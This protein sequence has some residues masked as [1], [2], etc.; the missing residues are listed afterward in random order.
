MIEIDGTPILLNGSIPREADVLEALEIYRPG[1]LELQNKI[2]GSTRVHLEGFCR[3]EECNLG[4]FIADSMVDWNTL[5]YSGTD[6]WTDAAIGIIQGGGVRASIEKNA[7]GNITME[8]VATVMPFE[9][10]V[11]VIE[12]TGKTLLDAFEHSVH[13]Y[14]DGEP[15]GEFLQFSGVQI[16]YDMN[17]SPGKRVVD[18]KVLCAYCQVPQLENVD[19][20]KK[21]RAVVQDFMANGGDGYEM[22][23]NS[24]IKESETLDVEILNEFITKKSPIYPAVEWRITIKPFIDPS[25]EIVGSSRVYLDGN[26][27]RSECNL[28]NFITDSFVDWYAFKYEAIG[29][30]TDASIAL[31]QASNIRNSFD[32]NT[33]NGKI[34]R[35]DAMNIL[36]MNQKIAVVEISGE[37]L[38]QALEHSVKRYS[39]G[40]QPPEFLQMSG[41]HVEFDMNKPIGSRV[42]A[43]KALC[44]KC[45]IPELEEIK[46]EQN[47]KILMPENLANGA[48]GFSMFAGRTLEVLNESELDAFLNYLQKKSPVYQAVEW[49]ITIKDLLEPSEDIVGSTRVFLNA[50]CSLGECNL[51]NF[52]TDSMV[53]WHA[54]NYNGGS[55]WTDASIAVIQ[56]SRIKESINHKA[57]N[58]SILRTD[59]QKI[60]QPTPYNLQTVTMKGTELLDLLEYSISTFTDG[61]R[62]NHEF[63]Q[64]SGI[65][66]VYDVNKASGFRIQDIKV[67]C[68]Q[69]NVPELVALDRNHNYKIIMQSILAEDEYHKVI[70]SNK[71]DDLQ[72]MDI[73]VFLQYLKKKSPVY[74]GVEWRI[75]IID[76]N[77]GATTPVTTPS[78]KTTTQGAANVKVPLLLIFISILLSSLWSKS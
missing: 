5:R 21:Y 55:G 32:P 2:V 25:E 54:Q 17:K 43:V 58:G 53:D 69:C 30:W 36:A 64:L 11:V 41:L 60:F 40:G 72:E 46:T 26:C 50:D 7:S 29:G 73:N 65:Q 39:E 38:R 51:G 20:L 45:T 31:I 70:T 10:K 33:N 13:R 68:A 37:V 27:Y 77:N 67:L 74:Q 49:R 15:R 19:P 62:G 9:S 6:G 59:V 16:E 56:G 23:K 47:Y 52:I 34:S 18:V 71:V 4:N 1:V 8:D 78:S 63:L 28:G 61:D 14:H 24:Q 57:H 22:L 3:R 75:T 35:T 12:V 48:E 76:K 44:S 66:V 42:I